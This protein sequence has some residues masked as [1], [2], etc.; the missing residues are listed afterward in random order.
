M[1]HIAQIQK[2]F[3]K[4]A[5]F[6]DLSYDRQVEYIKNH[7]STNLRVTKSPQPKDPTKKIEFHSERLFNTLADGG[8]PALWD[9]KNA[10]LTAEQAE[11]VAN[12]TLHDLKLQWK[13]QPDKIKNAELHLKLVLKKQYS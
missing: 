10:E 12:D 3:V 8:S 2:E 4:K 7:P 13:N 6:E 9:P 11:Q 1:K 5:T